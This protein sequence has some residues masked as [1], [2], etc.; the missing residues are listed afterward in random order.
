MLLEFF[1]Q[2]LLNYTN[3]YSLILLGSGLPH[4]CQDVAKLFPLSLGP[5]VSTNL[6]KEESNTVS[7]YPMTEEAQVG[8]HLFLVLFCQQ[9]KAW[10]A[11]YTTHLGLNKDYVSVR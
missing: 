3:L 9:Q 7:N 4:G 6:R 2:T 10:A 8:P 1:E 11:V 5:N